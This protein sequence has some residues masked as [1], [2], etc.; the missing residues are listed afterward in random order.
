[1]KTTEEAFEEI[2]EIIDETDVRDT[3]KTLI[4]LEEIKKECI[5]AYN[6]YQR[7]KKSDV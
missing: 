3:E 7:S 4:M 1:M 6:N 2:L 5:R